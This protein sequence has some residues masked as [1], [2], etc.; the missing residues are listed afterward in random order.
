MITHYLN[1]T[2]ANMVVPEWK[3]EYSLKEAFQIPD[4]SIQSMHLLLEK[5][6]KSQDHFQRY[7]QY[8]SV[9]YDLTYCDDNCQTDHLCA[10]SEVDFAKYSQCIQARNAAAA[11]SASILDF[12]LFGSITRLLTL[13][14]WAL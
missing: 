8:N 11:P 7:Y 9:Q 6:K 5:L 4:G 3:K 14:L 13:D 2:H 10:I 12:L 1:L